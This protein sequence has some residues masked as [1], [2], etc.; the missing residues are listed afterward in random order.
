MPEDLV[1]D[2]LYTDK[3]D[4]TGVSGLKSLT[5]PDD[6]SLFFDKVI[7]NDLPDFE[8][9]IVP[10]VIIKH[11]ELID[12]PSLKIF[13]T[14]NNT[15]TDWT[16]L[17]M[18]NTGITSLHLSDKYDLIPSVTVQDNKYLKSLSA[19][20]QSVGVGEGGGNL[21]IVDNEVLKTISF[22]NLTSVD[23]Y[24]EIRGTFTE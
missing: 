6:S 17:W 18:Q 7:L 5:L 19:T 14:D 23:E 3:I 24:L 15:I 10:S 16:H 20:F 4:A 1:L 9:L 12:L 13:P 2:G 8:K 11:L 22:P 21:T